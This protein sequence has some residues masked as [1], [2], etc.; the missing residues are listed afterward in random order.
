MYFPLT[1][2]K[3]DNCKLRSA[4]GSSFKIAVHLPFSAVVL[5]ILPASQC[6]QKSTSCFDHVQYTEGYAVGLRVLS[7]IKGAHGTHGRGM[8]SVQ[9][10][11]YSTDPSHLHYCGRC[12]KCISYIISMDEGVQCIGLPKLL[13]GLLVAVFNCEND[14]LQTI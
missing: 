10:R 11:V 2:L 8:P 6:I 5:F 3:P 1:I 12:E 14:I 9:T 4:T 7:T 13:R